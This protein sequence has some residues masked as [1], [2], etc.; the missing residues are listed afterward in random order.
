MTRDTD[1]IEIIDDE[2]KATDD[3]LATS[4]WEQLPDFIKPSYPF[5]LPPERLPFAQFVFTEVG[6]PRR[7]PEAA[8]RRAGACGGGDGP[9]CF[10]ADRK[11][12]W[13]VLFLWWMRVYADCTDEE[14]EASLRAKGSPYAPD[15]APKARPAKA[16]RRRRRR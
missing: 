3:A 9:P 11:Y 13:H 10:R 1:E 6:A 14:Y 4:W 7:C 16:A 8:C 12:L 2:D 15:A 5:D